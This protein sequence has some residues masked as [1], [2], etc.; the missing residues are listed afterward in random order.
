MDLTFSACLAR[1]FAPL[2]TPILDSNMYVQQTGKAAAIRIEVAS[3]K[4]CEPDDAVLTKVRG[5]F[6]ACA[7]LIRFYRHNRETLDKAAAASLPPFRPT[8][9]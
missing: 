2:V 8:G 7:R 9:T 5:A 4:I 6:E 1:L 3:F